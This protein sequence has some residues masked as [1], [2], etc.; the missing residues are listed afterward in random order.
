MS[1]VLAIDVGGTKT[2]LA[3]Y[4]V[5]D[6]EVRLVRTETVPSASAPALEPIIEAFLAGEKV[7]AA[8]LGVAGPVRDGVVKTTNL[9]WIVSEAA[10]SQL[11]GTPNVTVLNDVQ[12]ASFGATVVSAEHRH[13]IH[14]AA[15]DVRGPT[16]LVMIGTGFGAATLV[17]SHAVPSEAGHMSFS[18]RNEREWALRT[19]LATLHGTT[20]VTV[21][22]VLSGRGL[23][24]LHGFVSGGAP[25]PTDASEIAA[26]ARAGDAHA[27]ETVSWFTSLVGGVLGDL[28]LTTLPRAGVYLA[29]GVAHG[30]GDLLLT[31][32]LRDAYLDKP[33]MRAVLETI[34]LFWLDSP[35]LG[36]LGARTVA[37]RAR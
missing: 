28:A 24:D 11:L 17:H 9:P 34:P 21:E 5:T 36:L 30:L 27:T 35:G 20:H 29:G 4:E 7:V 33:P 37:M 1:R 32:T 25:R 15:R 19:H 8:G 6:V 3:L 10:L 22:H 14:A 26:R 23:L 18:A 31:G 16:T 12:A 2:A 13:A